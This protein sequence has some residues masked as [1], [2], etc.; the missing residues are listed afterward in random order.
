LV[1]QNG[2]KD[3]PLVNFLGQL[4]YDAIGNV[5]IIMIHHFEKMVYS[6]V[7]ITVPQK[8]YNLWMGVF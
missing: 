1:Q 3:Y 6:I 2:R 4:V 8:I 5:A 7:I